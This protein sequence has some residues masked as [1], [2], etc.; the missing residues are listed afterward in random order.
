[1]VVPCAAGGP[2]DTIGRILA[3]RSSEILGQQVVIGKRRRRGWDDGA[4]RVAKAAP[5]GYT[6][7]LP[8]APFSPSTRRS[9]RSR[10]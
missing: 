10:L 2:V 4:S 5:D 9:T 3:A 6:V 8:A 1:M 7:L